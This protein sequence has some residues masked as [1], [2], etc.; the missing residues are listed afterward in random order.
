MLK[1]PKSYAYGCICSEGEIERR[2]VCQ[3]VRPKCQTK[4][5][6]QSSLTHMQT[7]SDKFRFRQKI[8]QAQKIQQKSEKIQEIQNI[9]TNLENQ[10]IRQQVR[11]IQT[12]KEKRKRDWFR[13]KSWS[14]FIWFFLNLFDVWGF[15]NLSDFSEFSDLFYFSVWIQTLRQISLI[16]DKH[17]EVGMECGLSFPSKDLS[18]HSFTFIF[19]LSLILFLSCSHPA[20]FCLLPALFC[21]LPLLRV[22]SFFSFLFYF[23]VSISLSL[24]LSL[25]LFAL[26]FLHSV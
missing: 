2:L 15:L 16:V 11:Q 7:N 24:S 4:M 19:S 25:F 1:L 8:R 21:S 5:S 22:L 20:L 3:K 17:L 12:K 18:S 26:F 9:Q 13:P 23:F 14:E 6:N 10:K